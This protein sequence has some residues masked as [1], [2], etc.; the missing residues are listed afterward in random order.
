M[1]VGFRVFGI[2]QDR[3][4]REQRWEDQRREQERA[5]MEVERRWRD[6]VRENVQRRTNKK[7]EAFLNST[8]VPFRKCAP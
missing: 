2:S 1:K 4:T 3:R 8:V 6:K 5:D 7:I